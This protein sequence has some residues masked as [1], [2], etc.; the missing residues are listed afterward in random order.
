MKLGEILNAL[1]NRMG[2]EDL[3]EMQRKMINSRLSNIILLAPT[4]SGKTIAFTVAMLLSINKNLER[5]PA[6]LILVPSRELVLQT[7]RVVRELSN[8]MKVTA[9]YGGHSMVDEKNSLRPLPDI[10]V[11]TPGRLIDHINQK[12]LDIYPTSV[13]V[14]DEY[15]KSLELGFADQMK[16]IVKKLPNLSR[17]FLISATR[18]QQIPDFMAKHEGTEIDCLENT[19]KKLPVVE[20]DSPQ[21]DKLETLADL[22]CSLN[23]QRVV[24]FTNHR[25]SA[26]RVFN[27]LR[28]K[29]LPVG[30]Y[31]G[32]LEQN[33]REKAVDLLNNGTTPILVSTD[34][35]ARGL[36]IDDIGSIIHYHIP[37]T[38][39]TWT[40]RNGRT[41]RQDANGTIY[42]II[43]DSDNIPEYI[44][45][46]RKYTPKPESKNAISSEIASLHFNA[47]KK[48]KIS[49]GDIVGFL[50]KQGGLSPDEIGKITVRDHNIIVAVPR[51]KIQHLIATLANEKIKGKKVRISNYE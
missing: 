10:V 26:E 18:L 15:D 31:H 28:H 37:L 8:G 39:E 45:F 6:A 30:L 5:K 36:D 4:G 29:H 13:L 27:H 19:N 7:S 14:L 41:A 3:N 35:G 2:I 48:E 1:R 32:G 40:H 20:V 21:A 46:D 38:K 11:A 43:S 51:K 44:N 47:G 9:L 49:R 50:I 23:Q 33:D 22:L 42:V 17:T 12:N 25:E 34:L 24:I 16:K